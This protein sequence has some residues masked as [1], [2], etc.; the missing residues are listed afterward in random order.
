MATHLKKS[1]WFI[2]DIPSTTTVSDILRVFH[3]VSETG[4]D[5]DVSIKPHTQRRR[6]GAKSNDTPTGL[7]ARVKFK[8]PGENSTEKA[9]VTIHQQISIPGTNTLVAFSI[10]PDTA[11]FPPQGGIPRQVKGL[12]QGYTAGQLYD[13][14]RLKTSVASIRVHGDFTSVWFNKEEDIIESVPL[15]NG[16]KLMFQA[17]DPLTLFCPGLAQGT[18]EAMFRSAL[19]D[20]C[21]F[22]CRLFLAT[23][24]FYIQCEGIKDI[25]IRTNRKRRGS[26]FAFVSFETADQAFAA[27]KKLHETPVNSRKITVQYKEHN[28]EEVPVKEQK[29]G[30]QPDEIKEA[31]LGPPPEVPIEKVQQSQT[32]PDARTPIKHIV[33]DGKVSDQ[34]VEIWKKEAD[35]S[36]AELVKARGQVGALE[37]QLQVLKVERDKRLAEIQRLNEQ[38]L[39]LKKDLEAQVKGED[40]AKAKL[41]EEI[42]DLRR[43]LELSESRRKILEMQA[44]APMW[45]EAKKKR[46]AA[47]RK[48]E[49]ERKRKAEL[50]E[51]R[52]KMKEI[53]EAEA[54][55]KK[56]EEAAKKR[57][58][59]RKER[60]EREERERKLEKARKDR[61]WR[62]AT[63]RERARLRSMANNR[64]GLG[65]WSDKRALD[66]VQ[67]LMDEFEKTKFSENKP[68]TF[69]VIPWPVVHDP[70]LLKVELVDWAG[71]EKFFAMARIE[72]EVA[73][74]KKMVE[75]LHK[76]FHPDRW[77]ARA[78]LKTV[79]DEYL[80]HALEEAGNTVSQAMTPLW[81]A[82]KTL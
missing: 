29:P 8:F 45:K 35:S 55:R 46:E 54:R 4:W 40:K 34:W 80:S 71:V 57:E 1:V 28:L 36:K 27:K 47:E 48:A 39:K 72:L 52:R 13:L 67:Y 41:Q 31:E 62:E 20:V 69:E 25:R 37:E 42:N 12:P 49:A 73:E 63:E 61:E 75:R 66:R 60:E 68:A 50:E 76:M 58:Q 6:S 16:G 81:R 56:E 5:I 30:S 23:D 26:P 77:R 9:L 7:F 22:H 82:S 32:T 14:L 64:W 17:Y 10:H 53:Q 24:T 33:I 11:P 78:I 15:E 70:L 18:N 3:Q 74:Y 38:N 19:L 43:K 21:A 44:D 65:K 79:F 51:S 59:E 2:P